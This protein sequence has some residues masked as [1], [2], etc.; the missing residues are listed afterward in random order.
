MKINITKF[1][2]THTYI[3]KVLNIKYTQAAHNKLAFIILND[4][5]FASSF[6]I[7]WDGE[8]E[9]TITANRCTI[10]GTPCNSFT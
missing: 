2:S 6:S 5:I 4:D 3:N 1:L 8:G 9:E 10:T 7:G